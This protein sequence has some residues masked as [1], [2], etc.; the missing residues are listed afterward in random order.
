MS[1]TRLL[2]AAIG[3]MVLFGL[4]PVWGQDDLAVWKEFVTAV[5]SGRITL[6]RIRPHEGVSREMQLQQLMEIKGYHDQ[7][8]S[9]TEWDD[10]KVFPVG[11]QVHYIVT[12]TPGAGRPRATFVS[13]FSKRA[14]AGITGTSRTSSSV[15]TR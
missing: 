6:D 12:F 2:P 11:D 7:L 9:W 3:M 15:W 13:P 14:A 1:K 10:P 4:Q 8:K 5:K